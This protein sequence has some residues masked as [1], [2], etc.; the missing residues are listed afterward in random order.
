MLSGSLRFFVIE[1]ENCTLINS[2]SAAY[3]ALRLLLFYNETNQTV[4]LSLTIR[5]AVIHNSK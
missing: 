2:P 4:V 1:S 3:E 5:L